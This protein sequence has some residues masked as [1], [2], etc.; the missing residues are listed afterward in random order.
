M[1]SDE[2]SCAE[3]PAHSEEGVHGTLIRW[4][5]SLTPAER[6]EVLEQFVNRILEARAAN[7]RA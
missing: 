1:S 2:Q 7:S 6:L 4:M 3:Q 5:L